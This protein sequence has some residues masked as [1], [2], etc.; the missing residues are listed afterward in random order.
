MIV[1]CVQLSLGSSFIPSQQRI[2]LFYQVADNF[3]LDSIQET[4]GIHTEKV[5][6]LVSE[7]IA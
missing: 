1:R 3:H 2:R 4:E 7:W 5:K 6:M